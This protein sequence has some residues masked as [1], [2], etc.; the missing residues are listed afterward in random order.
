[1]KRRFFSVLTIIIA[2]VL[3]LGIVLA[4]WGYFSHTDD[5]PDLPDGSKLPDSS[6]RR[7][8]S[9]DEHV[10][11]IFNPGVGYTTTNWFYTNPGTTKARDIQG[12]VVLFFVGLEGFS[13]G[14]NDSG[15]DYDLDEQFFAA[16][17]DTFENCR[18]NGSTIG[19]RFRY[20]SDG[21]GNGEP[22][23]FDKVL[24]HISQIKENGILEDYKD[25]IVFVESGFVGQNGEHHGGKYCG[26]EYK[27][28][29]LAAM[30]DCV[31][32]PI[33]VTVRSA[34]TFAKY[35]GV[36]RS[37]LD[38]Y[39]A[40]EGSDAARVGLY[41][42]GYMGSNNDLGTYDNR[43][44][45][46]TW[47]GNQ[48]GA[49]YGGEFS[50]DL[51]FAFSQTA[52]LPENCI[53]EM[54]KTHLSYINGNIFQKYKEFTFSEEYDVDGYDNSAY[55]GQ[56]VF[57]FIRDHLG[58]RFVL[59]D[60]N[61]P[62]K[63]GQGENLNFSFTV[64]NN[65]FANLVKEQKCEIFL[66]K[67]GNFVSTEVNVDPRQWLTGRTATVDLE[68]KLPALVNEGRWNVYFK[69]AIGNENFSQFAF[70]S[71]Q[72]ASEGVWNSSLGANFLGYVDIV[73][74]E[75]NACNNTIGEVGGALSTAHLFNL[76]NKVVVDGIASEGEWDERYLIGQDSATG[77]KL[78]ARNDYE[79]MY[80]FAD[81]PHN[82][83]APVFNIS[84]TVAETGE[85]YWIYQQSNG[86]IHFDHNSQTGHTGLLIKYTDEGSEYKIPFYMLGIQRGSTLKS[87]RVRVQ[88]AS[89]SGWPGTAVIDQTEACVVA[90][91]F[92]VFNVREE[93]TVKQ[94]SE[95]ETELFVEADIA[96]IVWYIDGKEIAGE[97]STHLKIENISQDCVIS[98]KITTVSGAQ[99]EVV[100]AGI[101]VQN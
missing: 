29:I 12:D 7:T 15:V 85:S 77:Y 90:S 89:I 95:Y 70:R 16:L 91:E 53:P 32:Y 30:L 42:D 55:Y 86:N 74:W 44:I 50:G 41:N 51:G 39:V 67:D 17:R 27:A 62:E 84:I 57:Q 94:G 52:Y 65:G 66:E 25:I 36:E 48:S 38:T 49:Y 9:F 23:T 73:S 75:D 3:F 71:I 14:L 46:T 80:F 78:Y 22:A 69:S 10:G 76:C 35:V 4:I 2:V 68:I 81:M 24:E 59:K 101:K 31:P 93:L 45:E 63:L 28:Q 43:E 64:T 5:T 47:L 6:I 87:I 54:Y 37:K 40:S 72:F 21:K 97:K 60:S 13:S 8:F 56:T 33:P 1:M 83:K 58:Y 96:D 92:N 99:K 34:D 82:A 79:N 19:L 20:D 100:V 26:V 88:D 61:L 18:Q 11:T 98:V